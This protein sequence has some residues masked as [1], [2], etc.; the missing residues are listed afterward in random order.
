MSVQLAFNNFTAGELSPLLNARV[1]FAG[2]NK[3]AQELRNVLVLAQG[4]V[5]K[6]FGTDFSFNLG[7]VS[8]LHTRIFILEFNEVQYFL[9]VFRALEIKI[10]EG[11]TL[12]QT[13]VTP[14]KQDDISGLDMAQDFNDLAIVHPDYPPYVLSPNSD[15]T[16]WTFNLRTFKNS[17]TY[18]FNKNYDNVTFT[19]SAITGNNINITTS[20]PFWVSTHAGG[21]F[22]GNF[23][24]ARIVSITSTTVAVADVLQDFKDTNSILGK[25]AYMGEPIFSAERGYAKTVTFYQGRQ[26]YGGSKSLP[27]GVFLSDT[28]DAYNFDDTGVTPSNAITLLLGSDK[29]NI[30]KYISTERNLFLMTSDAEFSTPPFTDKPASPTDTYFIKQSDHGIANV[31]PVMIDDKLIYIDRGGKIARALVYDVQRAGYSGI[32]VSVLSPHL[33]RNPVDADIFENTSIND[34]VYMLLVNGDGTLA[35]FQ[36][37]EDQKI[38]AWTLTTTDGNFKQVA[39]N[40]NVVY[41]LVERNGDLY[42]ERL[43]FDHQ[44]DSTVEFTFGSPQITITGL[45]HLEGYT[46]EIIGDGFVQTPKRVSGGKVVLDSAVTTFIGGIQ[47]ES[48]IVPMPAQY[49]TPM[50]NNLYQKKRIRTIW[51]DY[52]ESLGIKING[53]VIP[54]LRF[55]VDSFGDPL[56]PMTGIYEYTNMKGWTNNEVVEITHTDPL[57][58]TILGINFG[59]RQ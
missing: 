19:P 1:G 38:N 26:A 23:G 31:K 9:L 53:K 12:K 28:F 15:S 14:Y 33:I 22:E 46:I 59:V 42:V 41:F 50:G 11:D 5:T 2:F 17:P 55:G 34:A 27:F 13:I 56:Q 36:M 20:V 43:T 47:I 39:A 3:G 44:T 40:S 4:G 35:I 52:Y 48:K 21:V 24:T 16:H 49:M 51:I 18:D 54:N 29:A 7:P 10:Y 57:P 58:F 37:I 6:R 30:I 32:N 8:A 25:N 45:E